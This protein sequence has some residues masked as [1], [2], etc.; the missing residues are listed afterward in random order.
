MSQLVGSVYRNSSN[1]QQRMSSVLSHS[2]QIWAANKSSA[3]SGSNS[4]SSQQQRKFVPATTRHG[5]IDYR[6]IDWNWQ[7]HRYNNMQ[8]ISKTGVIARESGILLI[9]RLVVNSR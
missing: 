8:T 3:R 6:L 7:F 4:K 1:K 2:Q 9:V 5:G